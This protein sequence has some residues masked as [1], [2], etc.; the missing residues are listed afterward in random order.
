MAEVEAES[1]EEL[2]YRT[3]V[4][5]D[6]LSDEM[7]IIRQYVEMIEKVLFPTHSTKRKSKK[8]SLLVQSIST[9]PE[10]SPQSTT[11]SQRSSLE[12]EMKK[13]GSPLGH[14]RSA[15]ID[16]VELEE[17]VAGEEIMVALG[18]GAG[19]R[20]GSVDEDGEEEEEDLPDWASEDEMDLLRPSFFHSPVDHGC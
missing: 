18:L 12:G 13:K 6:D 8:S 11:V 14:R 15:K 3:D 7:E 2:V 10:E 5:L 19:G 20:N 9:V 17:F 16:P 4:G 1:I